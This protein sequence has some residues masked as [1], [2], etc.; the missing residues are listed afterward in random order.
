VAEM[1]TVETQERSSVAEITEEQL[2]AVERLLE[3]YKGKPGMLIQALHAVQ[4]MVGFL[5][6]EVLRVVAR[7]LDI[8]VSEVFGVVTFYHYFSMK[9]RG[10]HVVQI[11]LGTAC[12]VRG[13][14][15]ILNRLQKDFSLEI[16]EVTADGLYSLEVMRCAG[17]CGL[18]P[19]VMIGN[20]V[21]K[22]VNPS[23]I[24]EI[25]RSYQ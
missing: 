17:A 25:V 6:P 21:H 24:T 15:E 12:Y 22:R 20:D 3:D 5:P 23:Q 14:Q 1:E 16:G 18:A 2:Q 4:N 11:C 9:P 8:P 13:G 7:T 10:K 19:V